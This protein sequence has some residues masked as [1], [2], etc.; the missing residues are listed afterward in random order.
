MNITTG[1]Q[2][3]LFSGSVDSWGMEPV[4][5]ELSN[6]P[7]MILRLVVDGDVTEREGSIT[8]QVE[9]ESTMTITAR[10]P[11][12]SL[13]FGPSTPISIGTLNGLPITMMFRIN[14]MGDYNSYNVSYTVFS[15]VESGS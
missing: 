3:V 15:G 4:E 11:H 2:K 7:T 12:V 6:A 1:N 13:D 14:V 10:N 8:G 5:F 9:N